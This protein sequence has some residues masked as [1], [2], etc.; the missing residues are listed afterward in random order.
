MIVPDIF[1]HELRNVL[2]VNERRGRLTQEL[3]QRA[4]E[5]VERMFPRTDGKADHATI[6][7]IARRHSLSAYNAAF[8]EL[9][10][11]S[12]GELATLDRRLAEAA[13]AEGL[14]LIAG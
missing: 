6:L 10:L 12:G 11:P 3:S 4:L 8:L 5:L 13:T 7:N 1:W 14:G 9:A 2:L